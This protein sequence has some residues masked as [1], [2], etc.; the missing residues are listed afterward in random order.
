MLKLQLSKY[1]DALPAFSTPLIPHQH[2]TCQPSTG[3]PHQIKFALS[4]CR[5]VYPQCF[6]KTKYA[7]L[8]NFRSCHQSIAAQTSYKVKGFYQNHT[9]QGYQTYG[10]RDD[11]IRPRAKYGPWRNILLPPLKILCGSANAWSPNLI[12]EIIRFCKLS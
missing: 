7:L 8:G 10:P 9:R 4:C 11:F 12:C 5:Q 3:L 2:L 6:T 1:G